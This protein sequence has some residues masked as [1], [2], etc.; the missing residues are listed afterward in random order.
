MNTARPSPT[1]RAWLVRLAVLTLGAFIARM[2]NLGGPA[3]WTDEMYSFSVAMH[4]LEQ[5]LADQDQTPPLFVLLLHFWIKV[6]GS[7]DLALRI[8]SALAGTAIVPVAFFVARR[9]VD[10]AFSFLAAGLLAFSVY[11][12]VISQEVRAYALFVLLA[13]TCLLTLL[14]FEER[15]EVDRAAVHGIV[16]VLL[17]YTHVY[18]LF[19]VG[20][21]TVYMLLRH[22]DDLALLRRWFVAQGLVALCYL[23]WLPTLLVGSGRVVSGFW[24]DPPGWTVALQT[25]HVLSGS[26]AG[27]YV[28]V[29]LL[30]L[31][32][33]WSVRGRDFG[34][35]AMLLW[36]SIALPI[37]VPYLFSFLVPIY[38]PKYGIPAMVPVAIL[39]VI[40]LQRL[41]G[42]WKQPAPAIVSGSLLCGSILMVG[43]Y[44]MTGQAEDRRQDWRAA[45]ALTREAPIGTAVVFNNGYCDSLSDADLMCA[46]DRYSDRTDLR[47][48]PFFFED[49]GVAPPVTDVSVRELGPLV[50][51]APQV[52]VLYSYGGSDEGLIEVELRRLGYRRSG[53][54]APKNLVVQRFDP[55]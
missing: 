31:A 51:G 49:H 45:V 2:V 38:I 30:A 17:L 9:C 32:G 15:T 6:A 23:P 8:P 19:F 52:W 21:H 35:R 5:L 55:A 37:V 29:P 33:W 22:R 43:M 53:T 18:A 36:L 20:A 50:A 25:A 27:S 34:D 48:V 28:A 42:T 41:T 26:E 10:P 16:S 39:A 47:L 7:S 54:W 13:G 11:G 24:L 14:R 44:F 1:S 4:P 3:L 40:A 12:V 46:F